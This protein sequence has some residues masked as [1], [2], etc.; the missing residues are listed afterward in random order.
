MGAA[1]GASLL[2]VGLLRAGVA[3][4]MSGTHVTNDG[5]NYL[6]LA[7]LYV[8]SFGTAGGVLGALW[9]L[10]RSRIGA[11]LLGYIGAA[12][13]CSVC[14]IIVMTMEH[15]NDAMEFVFVVGIGTLIFGTVAGYRIRRDG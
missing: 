4:V 12:I 11:Y 3:V 15:E 8:S 13:V 5:R 2:V 7:A 10:R 1:C 9:P 6:G 14:G